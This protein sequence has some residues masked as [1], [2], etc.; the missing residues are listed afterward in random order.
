HPQRRASAERSIARDPGA[1][2][3]AQFGTD[4]RCRIRRE[5]PKTDPAVGDD[6][7]RMCMICSTGAI[8]V[9]K[10][11]Y[12]LLTRHNGKTPPTRD[13]GVLLRQMVDRSRYISTK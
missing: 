5:T 6:P 4:H 12:T 10:R 7:A 9:P 3:A 1:D 2:R 13:G 8:P 11:S